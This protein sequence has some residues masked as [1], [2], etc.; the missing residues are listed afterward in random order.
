MYPMDKV[1]VMGRLPG[2]IITLVGVGYHTANLTPLLV[3]GV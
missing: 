1:G 2:V 3:V